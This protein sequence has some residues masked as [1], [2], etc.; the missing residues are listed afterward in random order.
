MAGA[1]RAERHQRDRLNTNCLAADDEARQ[2]SA[3]RHGHT[4]CHTSHISTEQLAA[5][6]PDSRGL[7]GG[8]HDRQAVRRRPLQRESGKPIPTGGSSMADSRTREELERQDQRR[9]NMSGAERSPSD[10]EERDRDQTA[11]RAYERFEARGREHGHD[12]EDWFE[13]ERDIRS[14]SSD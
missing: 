12:Q 11:R 10:R 5:V 4:N 9:E 6:N 2:R 7:T 14:R 8:R 3:V 13:A 1:S